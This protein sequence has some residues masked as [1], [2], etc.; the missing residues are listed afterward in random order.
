MNHIFKKQLRRFILVLFDN[1]SI[2]SKMWKEHLGHMDDILNIMEEQL[3]FSKEEKCE[4]GLTEI[5]YLGHIIG[6][7]GA[8][9]H[10]ENIQAILDCPTPRSIT[11]LRG[12]FEI[13]SYYR[14]FVKGFSQ[15]GAPMT[16]LTQKGAFRWTEEAQA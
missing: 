1:I 4:F 11:E 10:Q 8:K 15:V 14:R 16:D 3:F 6:V 13:C 2:Y 9:V 12:F 5:L 7:E